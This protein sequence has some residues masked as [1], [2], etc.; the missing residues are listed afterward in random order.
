LGEHGL[1][2]GYFRFNFGYFPFG[3]FHVRKGRLYGAGAFPQADFRFFD[4]GFGPV[5]LE[6]GDRGCGLQRKRLGLGNVALSHQTLRR[7]EQALGGFVFQR[8]GFFS[9]WRFLAPSA[10]DGLTFHTPI[11]DN[12]LFGACPR[13]CVRAAKCISQIEEAV[14]QRVSLLLRQGTQSPHTP[15]QIPGAGVPT[16]GRFRFERVDVLLDSL[17]QRCSVAGFRCF[18]SGQLI[19]KAIED[20]GDFRIEPHPDERLRFSRR[21]PLFV[22]GRRRLNGGFG[23]FD[24]GKLLD[25]GRR[26]GDVSERGQRLEFLERRLVFSRGSRRRRRWQSVILR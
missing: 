12:R 25:F 5:R 21:F 7:F 19:A 14:A 15:A 6:L 24:R 22:R 17:K 8:F 2:F 18:E 9:G 16:V 23:R 13:L 4:A 3:R 11:G 20:I 26:F 1:A 10:D